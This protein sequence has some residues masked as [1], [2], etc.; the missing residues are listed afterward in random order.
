[1]VVA[2]R[3]NAQT[4][5]RN[6]N[7]FFFTTAVVDYKS[8]AEHTLYVGSLHIAEH[9]RTNCGLGTSLMILSDAF[10]WH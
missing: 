4:G 8:V 3:T 2:H 6:G 9:T 5:N 1:M 7:V 10:Y